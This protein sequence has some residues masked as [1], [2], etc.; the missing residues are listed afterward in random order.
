MAAD[1][2]YGESGVESVVYR[3]V[4]GS[5]KRCCA[6]ELWTCPKHHH[7]HKEFQDP[8]YNEQRGHHPI[9]PEQDP[10]RRG[11]FRAKI[12]DSQQLDAS[13]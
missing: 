8:I 1:G 2:I 6:V 13:S 4:V 9:S 11:A 10:S 7:Q 12:E 3:K 5:G